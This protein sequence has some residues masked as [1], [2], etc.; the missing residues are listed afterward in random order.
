[1]IEAV[2]A[3]LLGLTSGATPGPLLILVISQSFKHN[4]KEGFKT[5]LVPL[6]TD[7]PIVAF[8]ILV[9]SNIADYNF[10]LACFS[11]AGAAFLIYLAYENFVFKQEDFEKKT[12]KPASIRKGI[13]A[14]FLS[15]AP[16]IFWL[17][18]GAPLF[19]KAKESGIVWG[20]L[21]IAFFYIGLIGAKIILA[22]IA[23]KSRHF[24]KSGALA[25]IVKILA[26]ILLLFAGF[27]VKQG[28]EL[29]I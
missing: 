17:T 4:F 29:L 1:M 26:F 5:A 20:I 19:I 12:H 23:D 11:F 8:A 21:F 28:V 15:P 24:L 9:L 27:L 18:V 13:L 3:L 10:V 16:Y 6:L 22:R 25:V 7:A 2:S 14:N